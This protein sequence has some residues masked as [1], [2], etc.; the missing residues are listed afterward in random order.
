MEGT[1]I[2]IPIEKET[3]TMPKLINIEG[4]NIRRK[5]ITNELNEELESGLVEI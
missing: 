3:T 1:E 5:E 2:V 4:G